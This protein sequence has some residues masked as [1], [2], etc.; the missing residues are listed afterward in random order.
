ME[1]ITLNDY[2]NAREDVVL[3]FA[4][5]GCPGG[6]YTPLGHYD[7]DFADR[8]YLL[9]LEG[10]VDDK[11]DWHW[12]GEGDPT[13]DQGNSIYQLHAYVDPLKWESLDEEYE[14]EG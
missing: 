8:N 1:T 10:T 11:G 6:D 12:D 14:S 7:L 9:D 4:G 13:D 3:F 5:Q 2:A